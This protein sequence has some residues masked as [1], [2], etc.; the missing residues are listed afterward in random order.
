MRFMGL[1][2]KAKAER[3]AQRLEDFAN[4]A[5]NYIIYE[6]ISAEQKEKEIKILRKAA[7]R[8]RKGQYDKVYDRNGYIEDMEARK[9]V[10]SYED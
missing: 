3:D 5:E 6:G 10:P 9:G 4:I 7:K 2:S 1:Y 8:L